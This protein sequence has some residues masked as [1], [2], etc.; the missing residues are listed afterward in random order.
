MTIITIPKILREKLT[1]E[2]ADALVGVLDKVEDRSEAHTLKVAEERFEKKV[3][4]AKSELKEDINK[5]NL[6]LE[7]TSSELKDDIHQVKLELKDDINHAKIKTETRAVFL[8]STPLTKLEIIA[9][10]NSI[11]KAIFCLIFY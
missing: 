10:E 5:V 4:K 8:M 6:H 2:G 1:E 9:N 7:Q 11:N 3:E